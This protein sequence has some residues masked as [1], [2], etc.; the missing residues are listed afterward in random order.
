MCDAWFVDD[1]LF[2]QI[3]SILGAVHQVGVNRKVQVVSF[4]FV[5]VL[6]ENK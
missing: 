3:F 2:H 4:A 5:H 1:T 6:L